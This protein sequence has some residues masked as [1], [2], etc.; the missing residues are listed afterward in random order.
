LIRKA[1]KKFERRLA[2]GGRQNK[3][4]FY[5]YVRNRTKARQSVGPLK[6]GGGQKVAD[7]L[8]MATL[9]N[10][11]FGQAFTREDTTNVPEPEPY[12]GPEISQFRVAVRE[13]KLKIKKLRR[14]GGRPGRHWPTIDAGDM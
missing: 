9:L 3:R 8:G 4:P 14:G 10:A 2:D 11:T 13:V 5:A 1:K 12:N 6:N 7:N